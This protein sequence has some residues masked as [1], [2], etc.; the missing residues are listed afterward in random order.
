MSKPSTTPTQGRT[1]AVDV[2]AAEIAKRAGR[3]TISDADRKKAYEEMR[4]SSITV[5]K[6]PN[7]T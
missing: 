1:D 2:R 7:D 5:E 3:D 4:K 6:A